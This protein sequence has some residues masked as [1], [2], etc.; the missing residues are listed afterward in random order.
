MIKNKKKLIV[1]T[2]IILFLL[3]FGIFMNKKEISES[4]SNEIE[5]QESDNIQE[6]NEELNKIPYDDYNLMLVNKTNPMD[7]KLDPGDITKD[8]QL[9]F[10]EMQ[11]DAK[12]EGITLNIRTSYRGYEQQKNAYQ[13]WVNKYGVEEAN[14]VSAKPGY[15]EH[16]TGLVIDVE[17]VN[18]HTL[19][20]TFIN[21]PEGK[22]LAENGYKYGF[23]IRY[24]KG[25]ENITGYSY[26]PW[27][28]R[29]VG[30]EHAKI[31][32]DQE[33][34]LEEYLGKVE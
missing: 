6:E 24:P 8:T 12:K 19:E 28:I 34:T 20:E 29:Y 22:Y 32:F 13:M 9:E 11:Q 14:R 4:D 16:H 3:M 1:I 33:I 10:N 18:G 27:H 31:I 5:M 25:K 21:T 23:I 2:G 7:M 17:G 30:K 26:E 15:S